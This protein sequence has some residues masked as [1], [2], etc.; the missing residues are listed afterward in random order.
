MSVDW[1]FLIRILAGI[2]AE[3]SPLVYASVVAA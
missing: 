1:A 2:L 3:S